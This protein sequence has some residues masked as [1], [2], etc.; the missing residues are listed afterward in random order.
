MNLQKSIDFLL[1]NAGPV[2]QY[3]LRKEILHDR[4]QTEEEYLLTQIYQTPHF[5][6]VQ[7]YAKPNGYIGSGVHS[8][9]KWRGE[10]LQETYLQDG[11][12]SARLLAY[13]AVP[14][15]HPLIAN[16]VSAMRNEET[17]RQ[18]F[19]Y[20][21]PEIPRFETRNVGLKSGGS[22]M[23]ILYTMQALLGYGDDSELDAFR[24]ISLEAFKS[25]LGMNALSDITKTRQ[26]KSKTNCP[27]VEADTYLPCSYHLTTLAYTEYVDVRL[28]PDYK[29]KYALE[30]DFTFWA[31]RFLSSI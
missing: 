21:P 2:I 28:E 29:R 20:I 16:F 23:V 19:S 3:R 22:L 4:S 24:D 8:W 10:I 31:V 18:E 14:K 26:S 9:G 13:Y 1:E 30:C 17:L 5:Q 6:A 15:T 7:R 11:E 25:L 12:A 27:Y